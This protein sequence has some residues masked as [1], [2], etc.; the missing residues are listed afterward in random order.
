M[1]SGESGT[2]IYVNN[3][4]VYV[5]GIIADGMKFTACYWKNGEVVKLPGMPSE[6]D[7]LDITIF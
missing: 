7:K 6:K 4:D 5:S 1:P 3:N 2:S